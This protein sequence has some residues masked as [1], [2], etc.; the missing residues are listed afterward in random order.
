MTLRMTPESKTQLVKHSGNNYNIK[1]VAFSEWKMFT[2]RCY[3]QY[4]FSNFGSS[5]KLTC[6]LVEDNGD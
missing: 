1:S 4:F 5:G 2:G 3:W 6:N